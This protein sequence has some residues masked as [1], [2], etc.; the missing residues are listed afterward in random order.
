MKDCEK[1][2][3][4]VSETEKETSLACD[5]LDVPSTSGNEGMNVWSVSSSGE[6]SLNTDGQVLVDQILSE[7][8]GDTMNSPSDDVANVASAKHEDVNVEK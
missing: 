5:T 2:G 8:I 4:A 7:V 1:V 3:S 6:G